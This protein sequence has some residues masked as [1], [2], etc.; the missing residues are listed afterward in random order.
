MAVSFGSK[1]FV[2]RGAAD[3]GMHG[4]R[5]RRGGLAVQRQTVQAVFE[6]RLDVAIGPRA[7]GER[8]GARGV[9]PRREPAERHE[10][11]EL[12]GDTTFWAGIRRYTTE[13]FG[14]SVTTEDFRAAME[15]ASGTDL[16][17]FFDRWV[18]K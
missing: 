8:T 11:R 18:Y 14:R 15:Q 7:G 2:V 6:D 10:L 12:L 3:V 13:H 4:P 1:R 17:A 5:A 9:E 16:G